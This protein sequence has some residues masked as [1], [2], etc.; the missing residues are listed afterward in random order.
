MVL[1]FMCRVTLSMTT[2]MNVAVVRSLILMMYTYAFKTLLRLI[3]TKSMEKFEEYV[4]DLRSPFGYHI[5]Q[6]GI[7]YE[8]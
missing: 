5:L 6:R 1:T 8:G 2:V 7:I 3:K 4:D